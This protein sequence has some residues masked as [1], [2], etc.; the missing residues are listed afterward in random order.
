MIYL[1][2]FETTLR[3]YVIRVL[4]QRWA[5]GRVSTQLVRNTM[6]ERERPCNQR[7]ES[8]LRASVHYYNASASK[9]TQ[10]RKPN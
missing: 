4:T 9:Y 5:V 2:L 3:R 8:C 6:E 7:G 1:L 10:S